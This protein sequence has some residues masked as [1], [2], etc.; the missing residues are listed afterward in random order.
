MAKRSGRGRQTARQRT[1]VPAPAPQSAPAAE[2]V[3]AT[4]WTRPPALPAH[5]GKSGRNRTAVHTPAAIDESMSRHGMDSTANLGPGRPLTP[6][7]GYSQPPRST[8][9]PTS[10]NIATRTRASWGLPSFETLRAIS[11]VY[12]VQRICINH[13]I[14]ELKSMPL[15]F[16]PAHG[17]RGDVS[18][19][20]DAARQV[21][22]FPDRELPYEA[23]LSKWLENAY[24]FDA[25]PLYK[26]RNM[27]GDVIGLEVLDGTTI[28]P[29]IDEDGRR[30]RPPAPAWYQI[31]K[32]QVWNWYTAQDIIYHVRQPQ[33]DSPFGTA[34]METFLLSA[35][36][37]L[38]FQ[39]H[40]LQLFTE[41]SIPGGF[42]E[43][44]PDVSSPDQVAEWQDYWDAMVAGD[45]AILHRLIA[46]PANT[47]V[48]STKPEKFDPEF[49][50]YL[51]MR[52]CAVHGVVPQDVGLIKDVNRS[53]GETQ[54]DIQFRVNTSP[55]VMAVEGVLSRYLRYDIGLPVRVKLD[56]GR[57]KED[58]LQEAQAHKLYVE[59]GAESPDEVRE[60]VLGLATD[61]NRPTPRFINNARMGPIPLP[62]VEAV[63]GRTDQETFGPAADQPPLDQPYAGAL[64]VIPEVGT[65]DSKAA[66]TAVDVEQAQHRAELAAERSGTVP[67]VADQGHTVAKAADGELAA[68]RRYSQARLARG[69][70]RDFQFT[71]LVDPTTA[72][73][74]NDAGRAAVRKAAGQVAVAGLAV[75]AADT[76][77]VL[78]LQRGLDPQD[79]A[80][81]TFEFPGGHVEGEETP[82][83]S[84]VREW[85]EE[86]G[87]ALPAGDWSGTWTSAN[88]I[89]QGSVFTIPTEDG[90]DIFDRDYLTNPDDPDGDQVQAL[91][92]WDSAQLPGNPAVRTELAADM[93]AVLA[94]LT[95]AGVAKAAEPDN[96]RQWPGWDRDLDVAHIYAD[97]IRR[98]LTGGVDTAALAR[99]WLRSQAV[100]KADGGDELPEGLPSAD[101]ISAAIDALLA[102]LLADIRTEGYVL[103]AR[104]AIS[105]TAG[106]NVDWGGW[107]P[108]DP[109]TA[110]AV[111][112]ADGLGSGLQ[113]LLDNAG[114]GIKSLGAGRF[115]DLAQAVALALENGDS[116]ETLARD[117][118][119]ILDDARWA[120]MVAVTEINRAASAATL[121]IY[122]EAGIPAKEWLTAADQRVCPT[123]CEPNAGDGPI[124]L[125]AAFSSGDTAPPGHPVCRCALGPADF[126]GGDRG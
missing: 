81:G 35:N 59:M 77:R 69:R 111:L 34:P 28:M 71:H 100:I 2:T 9:Y 30:P 110:D 50:E 116:A 75:R 118:R 5:I 1:G 112:G 65:A 124:P 87:L 72:H 74:L 90:L 36:T 91:A 33:E 97:R 20:L 126:M 64:G 54:T 52:C 79:P 8:D 101:D 94:A 99:D 76:G 17:V 4:T 49:P 68:F 107:T 51:M 25:A 123:I 26:R 83:Q 108:G 12:D 15:M 63:A 104:A 98:A 3:P 27:A 120:Y 48:T 96:A 13:K 21:L 122:A 80:A 85:L 11:K 44:P 89:Y 84:A 109:R 14:N 121:A 92:W 24:K 56:T 53:N 60:N 37:D 86:T 16:L 66:L 57:E 7:Q 95:P 55:D 67:T 73:R 70:W 39:W 29:Y 19:A 10:V 18:D 46:V 32:G 88:G 119:D 102:P 45:Q 43:V 23:W 115:D 114:I 82:E 42:I 62:S 22:E 113:Q 58:R 93:D 78:M 117:L 125:D 41:G 40:F 47:K 38:R 61:P 106:V 31:I 6:Q 103:G 105:M